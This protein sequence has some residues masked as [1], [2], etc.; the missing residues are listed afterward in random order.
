MGA[1]WAPINRSVASAARQGGQQTGG[2]SP[3]ALTFLNNIATGEGPDELKQYTMDA[4]Q[5]IVSLSRR[6]GRVL[7]HDEVHQRDVELC[8]LHFS[9]SAKRFLN[10][11][12]VESQLGIRLFGAVEFVQ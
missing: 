11:E 4:S 5:R 1:H 2:E 9:G 8:C 6:D 3:P 7:V 10:A 12:W